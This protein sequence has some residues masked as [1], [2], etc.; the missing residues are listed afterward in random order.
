M[1]LFLLIPSES[2]FAQCDLEGTIWL[3]WEIEFSTEIDS[4][5]AHCA[6]VRLLD[7]TRTA[8]DSCCLDVNLDYSFLDLANG[9]YTVEVVCAKKLDGLGRCLSESFYGNT[10][11]TVTS[12]GY[13]RAEIKINTSTGEVEEHYCHRCPCIEI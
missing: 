4:A 10:S 7:S 1:G 12:G 6:F 11:V 3:Y 13:L 5:Q 2:V 9:E 8:I